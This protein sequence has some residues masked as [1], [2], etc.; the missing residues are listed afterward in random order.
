MS[1]FLLAEFAN[2]KHTAE[3]VHAAAAAGHAPQDVLS[4]SPIEGITEYLARPRSWG[5]IGWVMFIAAAAGAAIGYLMQWYS[6]VFAYP[7]DSGGRPLNSWPAFLLV[8]YEL[9]IL[10]AGI[11]GLLG[12]MWMCGLPKLYHPLFDAEMTGRAAQDRYLLV[13][14]RD[15]KLADWIRAHLKPVA[16][17]EV[18]E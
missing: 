5:P 12:W 14:P 18:I 9:A 15:A 10:S 2:R 8:P 16:L 6:S 1:E 17:H 13:F 7:L 3:A 4:P 11:V